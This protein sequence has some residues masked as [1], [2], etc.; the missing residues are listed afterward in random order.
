[1]TPRL[2]CGS[3]VCISPQGKLQ[4]FS[5][6][7]TNVFISKRPKEAAFNDLASV[8]DTDIHFS[9]LNTSKGEETKCIYLGEVHA[10]G[11]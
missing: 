2:T 3:F 4:G 1:M 11:V 9:S 5:S 7:S 8:W 6:H 10:A